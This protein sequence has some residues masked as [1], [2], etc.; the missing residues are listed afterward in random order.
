MDRARVL[1]APALL[2][3]CA[4]CLACGDASV[5]GN[6]H[7]WAGLSTYVDETESDPG[8]GWTHPVTPANFGAEAARKLGSA[9]STI[10]GNSIR[11]I[12]VDTSVRV[13]ADDQACASCHAWT[14]EM[15]RASFCD[16]VP[17]F[18]EQPTSRGDG[19]DPANAKPAVLK[20]LLS[21]WHDAGCPD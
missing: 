17:S 14:T 2:L 12:V 11:A 7:E 16:R 4:P 10:A 5:P 20:A 21:R 1:F 6:P 18:L 3:L 8:F 9:E 13:R 19:S 15:D